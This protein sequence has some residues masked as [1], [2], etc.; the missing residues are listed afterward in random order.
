MALPWALSHFPIGVAVRAT[1]I[2]QPVL[3]S[4][5]KFPKRRQFFSRIARSV[6]LFAWK[7]FLAY[8]LRPKGVPEAAWKDLIMELSS[9]ANLSHQV[10]RHLL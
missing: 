3:D 9:G 10:G 5:L 8:H 2:S 4:V 6:A 1:A 7:R